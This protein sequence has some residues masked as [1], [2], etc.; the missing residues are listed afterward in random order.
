MNELVHVVS[1]SQ[2][3]SNSKQKFEDLKDEDQRWV[4]DALEDIP[5]ENYEECKDVIMDYDNKYQEDIS[6]LCNK[7]SAQAYLH[8]RTFVIKED[9]SIGVYKTDDEDSL[10]VILLYIFLNY[11]IYIHQHNNFISI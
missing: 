2:Y 1:K 3:E 7:F 5:E 4:L 10:T 8:D 6:D 11:L 9:N